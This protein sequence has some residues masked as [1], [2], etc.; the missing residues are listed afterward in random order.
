MTSPIQDRVQSSTADNV[1]P[2]LIRDNLLS[3][4]LHVLDQAA[5]LRQQ[6]ARLPHRERTAHWLERLDAHREIL[7]R[8]AGNVALAPFAPSDELRELRDACR[9]LVAVHGSVTRHLGLSRMS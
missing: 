6:A 9:L 4:A 3:A 1:L 2:S 7:A 8:R 5:A